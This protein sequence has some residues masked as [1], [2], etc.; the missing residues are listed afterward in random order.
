MMA[1]PY[2]CPDSPSTLG[3]LSKA[4]AGILHQIGTGMVLRIPKNGYGPEL[5][6]DYE[7]EHAVMTLDGEDNVKAVRELIQSGLIHKLTELGEPPDGDTRRLGWRELGL[8]GG[9][10]DWWV[11]TQ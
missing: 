2:D 6:C 7:T 3:Q 1:N 5:H 10:A 4:A 9:V 8:D 11:C